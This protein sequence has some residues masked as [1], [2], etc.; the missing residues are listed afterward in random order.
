[1]TASSEEGVRRSIAHFR[2]ALA[3][4]S[5]FAQAWVGLADVLLELTS[6]HHVAPADVVLPAREA[7]LR[8]RWSTRTSLTPTAQTYEPSAIGDL[9]RAKRATMILAL[10][11]PHLLLFMVAPV[12][13]FGSSPVSA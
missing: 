5:T 8:A 3:R 6:S 10:T 7:L 1:V 12:N 13:R 11:I 4:D 9:T 2:R